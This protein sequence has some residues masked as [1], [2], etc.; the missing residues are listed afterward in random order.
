ML[1]LTLFNKLLRLEGRLELVDVLSAKVP[2]LERRIQ[3]LEHRAH[4][5]DT[6]W[7]TTNDKV[8]ML[9]E[10]CTDLK[11]RS[12]RDN[13]VFI[14]L[15]EERGENVFKLMERFFSDALHLKDTKHIKLHF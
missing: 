9:Y 4:E 1:T 5:V 8:D 15:R 7:E 3:D 12:M 11:C 6:D 13:L 14:G 2:E 10:T